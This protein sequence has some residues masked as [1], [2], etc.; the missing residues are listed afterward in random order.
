[1]PALILQGEENGAN[2]PESS[3]HK[4]ELF[5]GPYSRMLVRGAGHFVQR[6]KPSV[7]A[8]STLD[9]LDA[10]AREAVRNTCSTIPTS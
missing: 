10:Y 4:E 8:K 1:V 6:E 9:W 3:E 7:V 2:T 5:S